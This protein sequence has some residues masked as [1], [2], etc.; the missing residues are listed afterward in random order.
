VC[1]I[2]DPHTRERLVHLI[3]H[4]LLVP[5]YLYIVWFMVPGA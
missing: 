1:H 3:S 2:Q 4:H 5:Y